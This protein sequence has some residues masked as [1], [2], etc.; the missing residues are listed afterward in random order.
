MQNS[1]NRDQLKRAIETQHGGHATWV[2]NIRLTNR[3]RAGEWDGWV[4]VFELSDNPQSNVAYAWSAPVIGK[5][6]P[7]V[8]AVLRSQ[9]INDPIKAVKAAAALILK[10]IPQ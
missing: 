3:N 8:F 9:T 4:S 5:T 6:E 7:R 1:S 10:S 2:R